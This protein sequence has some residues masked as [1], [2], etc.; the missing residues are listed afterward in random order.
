MNYLS[1]KPRAP[2][3]VFTNPEVELLLSLV[4]KH[5]TVNITSEGVVQTQVKLSV[6]ICNIFMFCFVVES[7][8]HDDNVIIK[9]LALLDMGDD[10]RRIQRSNSKRAE[11]IGR[12]AYQIQKYQT[13]SCRQGAVPRE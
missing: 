1:K 11:N 6:S 4:D 7:W 9:S 8:R 5:K 3:A 13:R 12:A 2:R 10:S